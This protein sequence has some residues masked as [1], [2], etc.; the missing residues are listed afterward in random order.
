MS[1]IY[2][3]KSLIFSYTSF[4]VLSMWI[5]SLVP[6]WILCIDVVHFNVFHY[7]ILCWNTVSIGLCIQCRKSTR[8]Q[9]NHAN[10]HPLWLQWKYSPNI[11]LP[12]SCIDQLAANHINISRNKSYKWIWKLH[13]FYGW[14][15]KKYFFCA[16]LDVHNWCLLLRSRKKVG[17]W[18]FDPA[19]IHERDI[20]RM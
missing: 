12:W 18:I 11:Y 8:T 9:R 16:N 10:M 17:N 15:V 5:M 1:M 6:P 13:C 2:C 19:G 7:S 3:S 4:I 14:I 20:L